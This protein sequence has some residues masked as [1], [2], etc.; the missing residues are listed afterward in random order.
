MVG[1]CS[2][3]GGGKKCIW[4][5][6]KGNW[7]ERDHLEEVGWGWEDTIKMDLKELGWGNVGWIILAQDRDK[8]S[9]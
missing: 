6:F 4:G 2:T 9:W 7:K 3:C 5:F 1:S 8:W